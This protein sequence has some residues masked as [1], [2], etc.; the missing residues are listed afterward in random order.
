MGVYDHPVGAYGTMPKI[1]RGAQRF[2]W[3]LGVA[4]AFF[5]CL[6]TLLSNPVLAH[7]S[8]LH[9]F[10]FLPVFLFALVLVPFAFWVIREEHRMRTLGVYR[11]VL[12]QRPP[13]SCK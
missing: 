11:A 13:P 5:V 9:T 4:V 3:R 8:S 1:N 6:L 10:V 2:N 7:C 12:F